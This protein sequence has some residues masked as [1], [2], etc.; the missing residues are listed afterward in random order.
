[1]LKSD[2]SSGNKIYKS[3]N[4]GKTWELIST[5]QFDNSDRSEIGFILNQ[6]KFY[7]ATSDRYLAH[8]N[9]GGKNYRVLDIGNKSIF[10]IIMFDTTRG[11]LISQPSLITFDNWETIN[12]FDYQYIVKIQKIDNLNCIFIKNTI[13]DKEN[14]F[15]LEIWRYNIEGKNAS[16]LFNLGDY[17]FPMKMEII[18]K[19]IFIAGLEFNTLSGGASKNVIYKSP[20][21]GKHWR[22]VNDVYYHSFNIPYLLDTADL[23]KSQALGG[24]QDITFKNDSVG[25][26]V[27]QFGKTVYT[28]DGGESWIYEEKRPEYF[29]RSPPVLK[30]KYAGD[31]P[32]IAMHFFGIYRLKKDNLLSIDKIDISD[33]QIRGKKLYMSIDIANDYQLIIRDPACK[34]YISSKL[35]KE[36]DLSRL[37]EGR[38]FISI[39]QKGRVIKTIGIIL[40]D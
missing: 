24:F 38:Y 17:M 1:M 3:I 15:Y 37:N 22:K 27:G 35:E 16:K 33:V 2:F 32:L 40:N 11:I 14:Q 36:N 34:V 21:L 23:L 6:K 9:D 28:Y 19:T 18:N 30:V 26:A 12:E 7:L 29:R 8:T 13:V 25:I 39:Y 5:Y 20:D 4:Q 10:G 31:T